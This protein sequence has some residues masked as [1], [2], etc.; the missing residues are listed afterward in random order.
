MKEQ[1]E[2]KR[3][4]GFGTSQSGRFLRKY[5]YD[6]FNA[7]EK[8][9]GL[10]RIVGARRRR[11]PGQLQSSLRAALAR[12]AH[13]DELSLPHDLFPFTDEAETDGVTDSMLARAKKMAWCRIFLHQRVL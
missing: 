2:V 5:L 13:V 11:R 3:A 7:D 6:G 12:R 9:A 10:R 1:G 8:G 4:I